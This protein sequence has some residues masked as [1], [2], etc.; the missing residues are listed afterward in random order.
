MQVIKLSTGYNIHYFNPSIDDF[1]LMPCECSEE[2]MERAKQVK[3]YNKY[4][5]ELS[6]EELNVIDIDDDSLFSEIY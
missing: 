4:R 3:L 6:L 1:E 5:G 2:F